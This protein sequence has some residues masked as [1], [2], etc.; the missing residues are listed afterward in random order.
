MDRFFLKPDEWGEE[1]LVLT[2][3]EAH[4]AARVMRKQ[5]GDEIE[6]FDGKGCWARGPIRELSKNAATVGIQETGISEEVFPKITLAVCIPK[7][8][9]MDLIVQKSVE[10]GVNTI[11]PLISENT[12]V[13]ISGEKEAHEKSQKWQRTALE[14]CKQCGQNW[15]PEVKPVE[16]LS[17][18][19]E[20]PHKGKK[21]IGALTGEV[22][23]LRNCLRDSES[24]SFSVLVGPE[25]DFC[26]HELELAL[27]SKFSPVTL[28]NTVLRVETAC[29]CFIS[30]LK[31]L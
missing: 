1:Q 22:Q 26:S 3:D 9:T 8:K 28:G 30:V 15:V 19:L 21:L 18:W 11:Q 12:V 16:E 20:K 24:L 25:G 31:F 2:G 29:L 5:V 27:R 13:K 7:G 14:A 10:L 6:I 4:H 23:N 17:G